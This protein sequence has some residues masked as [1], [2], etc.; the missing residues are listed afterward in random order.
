MEAGS[1]TRRLRAERLADPRVQRGIRIGAPVVYFALLLTFVIK[2]GIPVSRDRLLLWLV[3]GLLAFSVT[4]VRGWARSVVLEW[5]PLAVILWI[6]DISRGQADGL[7]FSAHVQPQ[8]D[9]DR[10]LGSAPR[11]P[12]SSSATSGT[13]RRTSIG[14]TTR[15]GPRT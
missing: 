12:S 1:L 9:I 4:N 13:A 7:F 8:L 2:D 5:L 14:G 10:A 15:P 11:R 6:Y 3:L